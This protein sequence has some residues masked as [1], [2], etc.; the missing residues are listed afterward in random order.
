MKPY[1]MTAV[2]VGVLYIIGTVSGILS[3][4]VTRNLLA[5][6]D[7]LTRIAA[8]P[9]QLNLGAFFV[10]LMGLSL[11][12]MPIFLYP[13]FK[14]KNEALA[15]GM[16]VFRGPLEGSTYILMVV[17]WLLLGVFSKEFT[18]A[19]AEAASLQVI[20]NVLLQAN[21]IMSPVLT[22]VFIIGAM[23]LYTLFYL[24]KLIPRW[25]SGWGLIGAVIYVAVD[26]LKLFGLNLHLDIL[27]IPLAVQEMAMA[28][29]LIIKGF[30]QVALDELLTDKHSV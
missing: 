3:L 9:S 22:I 13:L 19:G 12:A 14:K 30:N 2:I 17:S 24:T 4:V 26:L 25:L 7:F 1:R 21:D 6:E 28:L 23:L 18:A 20:G 29:W 27:Y 11:T 8:N 5:G 10:L 16:V 15:L